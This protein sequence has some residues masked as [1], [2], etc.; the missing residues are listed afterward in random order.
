MLAGSRPPK[1]GP[2]MRPAKTEVD[3]R[4]PAEVIQ[5]I[6]RMNHGRFRNCYENALR[7]NPSLGGRVAVRFVIGR[8]GGVS[9][10]SDGGSDLPDEGVRQCVI[11]SFYT[12]SFPSPDNGTVRV[13][14]PLIFTPG[15]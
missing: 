12:L 8:D 14:Y 2:T 5:R 11:R 6:V 7:T 1:S 9:L 13:T 3:G 15:E 4:L 10:A